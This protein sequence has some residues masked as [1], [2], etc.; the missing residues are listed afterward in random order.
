LG[1]FPKRKFDL[2]C[3][4]FGDI[5]FYF[6]KRILPL[7]FDLK[8]RSPEEMILELIPSFNNLNI[9]LLSISKTISFKNVVPFVYKSNLEQFHLTHLNVKI[10]L[11]NGN[12]YNFSNYYLDSIE[13][14]F[15][16]SAKKIY[17]FLPVLKTKVLEEHRLFFEYNDIDIKCDSKLDVQ[18][19][20]P[21]RQIWMM[22]REKDFYKLKN[23]NILNK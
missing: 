13:I 15:V 18:L 17:L 14:E 4:Y 2:W 16:L 9:N 3:V 6:F 12:F 21:T 10:R 7:R 23:V 11:E 1:C 20:G 5:I 22:V 8:I 19:Y